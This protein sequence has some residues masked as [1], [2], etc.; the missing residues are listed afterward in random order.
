MSIQKATF[1]AGCFWGVEA[2]FREL[3]GIVDAAVGYMGGQGENPTYQDVCTG[4]TGHVEVV[5]VDYD[6]STVGYQDLLELFFNSHNPTTEN[7][8]GLD[9]GH[10]YRSVIFVRGAAQ[11]KAA[12]ESIQ[13]VNDSGRWNQPLVTDIVPASRFWRAEEYHQQYLVKNGGGFCQ[14]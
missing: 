10:Q 3:P 5:E 13:Q 1:G 6:E 11:E 8:Q 9:V 7:R 2:R 4:T 14:V 12:R